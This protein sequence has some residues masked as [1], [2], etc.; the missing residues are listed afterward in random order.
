[1]TLSGP[2]FEVTFFRS[3]ISL[4]PTGPMSDIGPGSRLRIGLSGPSLTYTR[5]ADLQVSAELLER[6]TLAIVKNT[7]CTVRT[8][9]IPIDS[10][11]TVK[12]PHGMCHFFLRRYN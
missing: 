8:L 7:F 6:F 9:P 4:V 11:L 12:E 5:R 3:L 10:Y 1:M 2:D